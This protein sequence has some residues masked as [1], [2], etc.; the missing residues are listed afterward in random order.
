LLGIPGIIQIPWISLEQVFCG[1]GDA[2][3]PRDFSDSWDFHLNEF[4]AASGM[5][6][7]LGILAIAGMFT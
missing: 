2:W 5:L 3:D 4:P 7:I 1:I 6:G